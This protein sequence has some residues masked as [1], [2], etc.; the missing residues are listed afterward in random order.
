MT[1]ESESLRARLRQNVEAWH[2]GIR[3]ECFTAT[4]N[5][6]GVLIGLGLVVLAGALWIIFGA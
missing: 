4:R 3:P 2:S 6:A 5:L 1:P